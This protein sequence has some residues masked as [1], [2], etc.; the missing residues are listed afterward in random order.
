[1]RIVPAHI[2]LAV[3]A[4]TAALLVGT[5]SE[6]PSGQTSSAREPE[7][8]AGECASL[9]SLTFE[10]NTTITTATAITSGT[11]VVS[12]DTTLT[13]L[14]PF[15]RVQGVSKPSPDSN[16]MFE[17]WLPVRQNWNT[18]FLSAGEGGFAGVPNYTRNGLDGALD[19]LLRRGYATAGTD[20]GHLSTDTWWAVGH[21][22][23]AADY[24]YRSKHLVT[25]AAKGLIAAYYGAPPSHSYFSSCSNGGRQG[26]IEVQRYPDDYDG[27]VVGAP[28]NFQSHS[29]AG[30]IWNQQVL[31]APAAAIPEVK[32]PALNA[33]ALAAC[34]ANDG[35]KDGVIANPATCRFDPAV[36]KC[37]GPDTPACLTA[38]QIAAL[39][40]VYEGPTHPRTNAQIFPGFAVGGEAGWAPLVRSASTG[41]A[42]NAYFANVVSENP[43]WDLRTFNFDADVATADAKVGPFGNAVAVDYSSA[44]R[45][46]V[47]I[48]Q[49][50]GWNDQTLQPAYSPEYY[51]QVAHA[52]GGVKA[53]QNFYRLYMVP[54]MTHCYGGPGASSFGGVGQQIPPVRDALH[55]VQT[56]L[57]TWVEKGV[58]PGNLIATKFTDDKATTRTVQLTR[59]LCLY[60]T[61]PR[62]RG[63]GDP[64]DAAN[65]SCVP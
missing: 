63:T 20:T 53:T 4:G 34:D 27:V 47:K 57:E 32:L 62:Y 26:L 18:K 21:P 16:I 40:K 22:E 13:N 51:E 58:A 8:R 3:V 60:P 29:A 14:P 12:T 50:H 43:K 44:V 41:S 61:T 30:F 48:I 17:V 28:W 38:P 46:G 24:L 6:R 64:N 45:R 49:Y 25:V 55:D 23:K 39:K 59:P 11:T 42:L 65:F 19:E 7:R 37:N 2:R 1:M 35:L 54:G 56:A 52:N 31:S 9:T 15:C 5:F 36:L 10:G 33:A